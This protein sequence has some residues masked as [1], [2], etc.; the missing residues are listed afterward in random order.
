M[1]DE[2][3]VVCSGKTAAPFIMG[4]IFWFIGIGVTFFITDFW[5]FTGS[6]RRRYYL[7]SIMRNGRK[8][9]PPALA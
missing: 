2:K 9:F 5:N 4:V 7:F 3:E 6:E 8:L 1:N